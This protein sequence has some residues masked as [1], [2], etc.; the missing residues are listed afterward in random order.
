[1]LL[2]VVVGVT[3]AITST[4]ASGLADD[5]FDGGDQLHVRIGNVQEVI[6]MHE[7]ESVKESIFSRSPRIELVLTYPGK[8]GRVIAFVP[9]RY[10]LI[11]LSRSALFHELE[12]R[13][14]IAQAEHQTDA[15]K[16][17]KA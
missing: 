3:Y 14:R 11:P 4:I 13:V 5:V 16:I 8:F 1:V 2:T 12:E 6:L 7:I 9:A 17:R 15:G 10:S